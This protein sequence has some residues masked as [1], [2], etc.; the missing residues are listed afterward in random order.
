MFKVNTNPNINL[1]QRITLTLE[2]R[3]INLTRLL[4]RQKYSAEQ[5]IECLRKGMITKTNL[6]YVAY[7]DYAIQ[8]E[9]QANTEIQ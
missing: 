6:D 5:E 3:R 9:N 7:K 8:C 1:P 2:Q 4:I